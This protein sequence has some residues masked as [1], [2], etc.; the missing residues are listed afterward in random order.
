M[1]RKVRV[2]LAAALLALS[3]AACG[4]GGGGSSN[5]DGSSNNGD[6]GQQQAHSVPQWLTGTWQVVRIRFGNNVEPYGLMLTVGDSSFEY[7]YPECDVEGTLVMDPSVPMYAANEYIMTMTWADC[8]RQ[9]DI[10]TYAGSEDM[11]YIWSDDGG[12]GF[13]RISWYYDVLW[14]YHKME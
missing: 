3:L 11:G 10:P 12:R 14:V 9:W 2:K 4:G 8:D 7:H 5:S 6:S 13:Y 1:L